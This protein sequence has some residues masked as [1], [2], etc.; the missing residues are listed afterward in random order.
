MDLSFLHSLVSRLILKL[1]PHVSGLA[2]ST[3]FQCFSNP[4]TPPHTSLVS[5][6]IWSFFSLM[7]LSVCSVFL[8]D[9]I[10][11]LPVGMFLIFVLCVFIDLYFAFV[12][13]GLSFF[14]A[15]LSFVLVT[16][17]CFYLDLLV[18]YLSALCCLHLGPNFVCQFV[19]EINPIHSILCLERHIT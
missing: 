4:F 13:L 11:C 19:T 18:L 16:H 9:A 8:P 3:S 12:A 7:S 2:L 5:V 6:C 10:L 17:F 1:C 14:F 15:T